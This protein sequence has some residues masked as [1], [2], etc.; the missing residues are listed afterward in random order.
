MCPSPRGMIRGCAICNQLK[1]RL[2]S[3]DIC[4][5]HSARI[6]SLK[7]LEEIPIKRSFTSSPQ[8]DRSPPAHAFLSHPSPTLPLL[9]PSH[10]T[11]HSCAYSSSTI[12]RLFSG[13]II[14]RFTFRLII[15]LLP[16]RRL[17]ALLSTLGGAR[18]GPTTS[19]PDQFHHITC[20]KILKKRCRFSTK[21]EHLPSSRLQK[22]S[23]R[24]RIKITFL[25]R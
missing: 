21:H 7:D 11:A 10:A 5:F 19:P 13:S 22:T 25:D 12:L 9:Y 23:I 17:R 20:K 4:C 15:V 24:S 8:T 16:W 18:R 2:I 3:A 14:A 6:F 1:R